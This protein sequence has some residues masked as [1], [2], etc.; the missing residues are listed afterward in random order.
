MARTVDGAP[1][2]TGD[3]RLMLTLRFD[4]LMLIGLAL[5]PGSIILGYVL[6]FFTAAKLELGA[7][8]IGAYVII[9]GVVAGI[10][11][12]AIGLGMEIH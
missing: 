10:L 3:G 12:T 6:M 7:F 11:I 9:P 4:T 2:R 8:A 1:L 5:I